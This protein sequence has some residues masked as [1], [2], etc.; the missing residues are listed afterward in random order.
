MASTIFVVTD[1]LYD[2][3][4]AVV[5]AVVA[6]LVFALCWFV[7]PTGRRVKRHS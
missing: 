5:I 1:V 7:L 2:T 3:A 4:W 6:G